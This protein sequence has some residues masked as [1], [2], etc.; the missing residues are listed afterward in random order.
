MGFLSYTAFMIHLTAALLNMRP[1]L[2][3]LLMVGR[4]S[5]VL[6]YTL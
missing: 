1:F 4:N 5:A 2:K 6:L 3:A